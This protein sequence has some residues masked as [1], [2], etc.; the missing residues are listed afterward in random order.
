MTV[1]ATIP[2][3]CKIALVGEA[4]GETEDHMGEPFVGG[5]G[6]ELSRMLRDAEIIRTECCLTN[7]FNERPGVLAQN[8]G[9]FVKG[10]LNDLAHIT[11]AKG[12]S[13]GL[14]P[15]STGKYFDPEEAVPALE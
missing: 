12:A 5:A 4:P 6:Q 14:P 2:A 10:N 11:V 13:G 3:S 15:Y 9:R 1:V 7:L 8:K